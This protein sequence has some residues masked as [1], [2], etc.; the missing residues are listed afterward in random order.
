MKKKSRNLVLPP[1][2]ST[3]KYES[4][5]RPWPRGLTAKK[6]ITVTLINFLF[7]PKQSEFGSDLMT[8]SSKLK[9]LE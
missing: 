3:L 9:I 8:M 1:S 5:N 2:Q 4:E 6:I 7:L